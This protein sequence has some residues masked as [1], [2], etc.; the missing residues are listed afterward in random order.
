MRSQRAKEYYGCFSNPLL[1]QRTEGCTHYQRDT[2]DI[3]DIR[4]SFRPGKATLP[5]KEGTLQGLVRRSVAVT[6]AAV[7][8]QW[9]QAFR[10][11]LDLPD[12]TKILSLPFLLPTKGIQASPSTLPRALWDLFGNCLI[13]SSRVLWYRKWKKNYKDYRKAAK[14]KRCRNCG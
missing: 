9:Q 13:G 14:G 5:R 10:H 11:L 2:G 7:L 12:E 1:S 3:K 8:K 4:K 6:N